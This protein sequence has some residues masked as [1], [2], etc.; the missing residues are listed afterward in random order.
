VIPSGLRDRSARNDFLHDLINALMEQVLCPFVEL[1]INVNGVKSKKL[2]NNR[3]VSN[4]GSK[5]TTFITKIKT[6]SL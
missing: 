5:E 1:Q 4:I 3:E 6:E 2:T